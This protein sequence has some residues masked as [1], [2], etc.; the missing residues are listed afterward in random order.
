MKKIFSLEHPKINVARRVEAIKHEIKKYQTRERKKSLPSDADFWDFDCKFGAS[1]SEAVEIHVAEINKHIDEV[2]SQGQMS[3]Y[4]ELLVTARERTHK[5]VVIEEL[6][7]DAEG[8]SPEGE[9]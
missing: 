8:S 3:F 7:D 2:E 4:L 6:D 5:P 9:E 1:E